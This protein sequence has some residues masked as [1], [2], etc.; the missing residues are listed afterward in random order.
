MELSYTN[1]LAGNADGFAFRLLRLV[2]YPI[3]CLLSLLNLCIANVIVLLSISAVEYAF[4]RTDTGRQWW[5]RKTSSYKL[6]L[7]FSVYP[8]VL[9]LPGCL[10]GHK[11]P[12][13]YGIW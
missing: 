8:N 12:Y 9:S 1:I 11:P 3:F 6:T 10:S 4:S 2:S 7:E 5:F 13:I